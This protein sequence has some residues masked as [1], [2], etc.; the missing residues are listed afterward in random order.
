MADQA[1]TPAMLMTRP[2]RWLGTICWRRLT[3]LMLKK[4]PR[5][6]MA[7]H[8]TSA[9]QYQ[10]VAANTTVSRPSTTRAPRAARLNDSRRPQ[11]LLDRATVTSRPASSGPAIWAAE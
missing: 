7:A 3:V 4:M 11:H 1:S 9:P 2:S 5:P 8:S 10:R 6:E